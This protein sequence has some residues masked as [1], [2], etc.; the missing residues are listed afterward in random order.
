M[1][2]LTIND[3]GKGWRAV[4]PSKRPKGANLTA[5]LGLYVSKTLASTYI[6]GTEHGYFSKNRGLC[7]P[8]TAVLCK[9]PTD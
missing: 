7:A 2:R 1:C 5:M 9:A 8:M 6:S 3:Q 4:A